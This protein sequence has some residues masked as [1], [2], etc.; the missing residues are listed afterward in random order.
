MR[1]FTMVIS[2]LLWVASLNAAQGYE[3]VVVN[4]GGTLKG[5]VHFKG[6]IPLDDRIV[7]DKNVEY[8]SKEKKGETYVVSDSKVKNV[9]VWIE[10]IEKGKEI[11]KNAIE[12]AIRDCMAKPH[13]NV[14]FVGGKYALR[15][16]DDILH[17]IQLKLGLAYQKQTSQRP[18]ADGATIYNLAFPIK[19]LQINKP[20][21]KYHRYTKET[22]F[23]QIRSN[24]HNWI[25]VIGQV[26]S[27]KF[28][29]FRV[30]LF[31][32]NLG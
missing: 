21:K 22:G 24:T 7:I 32:L 13:V 1:Y 9:I 3:V 29:R 12:V 5:T 17:T 19:G 8:C 4:N 16:D 30:T 10:G 25:S 14:G 28:L 26:K 6:P 2:I 31:P 18:L 23:I 20:I 15:N 11:P 27:E